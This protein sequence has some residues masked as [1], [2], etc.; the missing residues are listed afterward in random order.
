[1]AGFIESI[2]KPDFKQQPDSILRIIT[3]IAIT[4]ILVIL[5]MSG[6]L[7]YR[8]ISNEIIRD[9]KET[10]VKV[11]KAVVGQQADLLT[12]LGPDGV[13]RMH[14]DDRNLPAVDRF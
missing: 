1:M 9:A 10:A 2:I 11:G 12:A 14:V 4:S 13:A 3:W 8:V 5:I 7:V 6:A